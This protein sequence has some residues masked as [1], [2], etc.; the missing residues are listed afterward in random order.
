MTNTVSL[1]KV[2][3]AVSVHPRTILRIVT[4]ERNTYWATD[5]NPTLDVEKV[6][7]ALGCD[8]AVLKRV[9]RGSDTFMKPEDAAAELDVPDRTFRYRKYTPAFRVG[10]V[11]RFARSKLINEHFAKWG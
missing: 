10:R 4:G 3:E 9:L 7:T 8:A 2:A 11:V 6:A 5:H 1:N